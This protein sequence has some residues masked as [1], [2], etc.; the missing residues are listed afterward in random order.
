MMKACKVEGKSEQRGVLVRAKVWRLW[1]L[2]SVGGHGGGM[3]T[4]GVSCE[5]C[6]GRWGRLSGGVCCGHRSGLWFGLGNGDVYH[7]RWV[8]GVTLDRVSWWAAVSL[9]KASGV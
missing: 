6:Q 1:W 4:H 8:G 9:V 5:P 3:G 7:V 2:Y